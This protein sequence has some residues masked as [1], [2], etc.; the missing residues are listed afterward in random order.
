MKSI[1]ISLDIHSHSNTIDVKLNSV[2]LFYWL[3]I[4]CKPKQ[5]TKEKAFFFYWIS[6]FVFF[7]LFFLINTHINKSGLFDSMC[8]LWFLYIWDLSLILSFLQI[9]TISCLVVKIIIRRHLLLKMSINI[10]FN[11][12]YKIFFSVFLIQIAI[13]YINTSRQ[14]I[15]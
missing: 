5:K 2:Y 13:V 6:I 7:A 4:K 14:C 1:N 10:Y 12:K 15:K 8:F 3:S 9:D 11:N